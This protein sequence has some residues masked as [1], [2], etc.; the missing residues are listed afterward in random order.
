MIHTKQ[1]TLTDW[2]DEALPQVVNRLQASQNELLGVNTEEGFNLAGQRAVYEV[3]DILLTAMFPGC[4]GYCP[5]AHR[6]VQGFLGDQLR[7]AA[8]TL[9]QQITQAYG[10]W[11]KLRRCDQCDCRRLAD[12]A[13]VHLMAHLPDCREALVLDIRAAYDGDPAAT[14]YEE[15]VMAYP[16]VEAIATYRIAH[17]LWEA[18]VPLIPRIMSER[19]HSRTGI[20]IHPGARIGPAFFIDHGTGV[21]IGETCQIGRNVKLYQGVTLGALSFPKDNKGRIVRGTK[22]HPTI[23]DDVVIYANA[24]LLGGKTRIGRGSVIG[25][26]VWLTTSVPPY[27]KVHNVPPQVKVRTAET[28]VAEYEI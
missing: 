16:C 8:R 22:R 23:E 9:Q 7:A 3:L 4:H 20:D 6:E 14:S 1:S 12:E 24:T 26:N 28:Y 25:S 5:L 17:Q 10:Y 21:V 19:A 11:C 18:N 27:S 2:L 15:I 13:V